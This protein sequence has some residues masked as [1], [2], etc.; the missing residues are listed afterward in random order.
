[1]NTISDC[2]DIWHTEGGHK[3]A[4]CL[5]GIRGVISN[6]SQKITPICC[7]TYR[8]NCLWEE[9]E[10]QYM[11]RLTIDP[12]SFCGLKVI[13]LKTTKIQQKNQR[14]VTNYA[15]RLALKRTTLATP[16]RKTVQGNHL[17]IDVKME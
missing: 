10:N 6:Y 7:H 14:C 3:D 1:M 13:E 9:A 5:A 17:K 8:V 11:N 16:T 2:I 4:S 15:I 12:Q